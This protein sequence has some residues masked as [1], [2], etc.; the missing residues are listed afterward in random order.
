MVDIQVLA[1]I[2]VI[3][4]CLAFSAAVTVIAAVLSPDRKLW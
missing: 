1:I 4:C 3:M 2:S